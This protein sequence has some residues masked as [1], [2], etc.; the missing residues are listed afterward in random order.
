MAGYQERLPDVTYGAF[1]PADN[2]FQPPLYRSNRATSGKA[3]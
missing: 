1:L 3:G 2:G